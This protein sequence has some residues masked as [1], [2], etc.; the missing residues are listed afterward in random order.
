[1]KAVQMGANTTDPEVF[2]TLV[3][4]ARGAQVFSP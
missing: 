4:R 2:D 1:V 3:H